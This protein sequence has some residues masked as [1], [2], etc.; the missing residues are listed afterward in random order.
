MTL[1]SIAPSL[2]AILPIAVLAIWACALL[3]V[4]LLIPRERKGITAILAALGLLVS[5]VTVLLQSGTV[6]E[7]FNGMVM[8][9]QFAIF[10]QVLFLVTGL[11]AI[12]LSFNYLRRMNLERSEYYTLLLFSV[13]GMM[14]MA[15]ANDLIIV[16]LA[17]ELLSIPLYVMAG[18]AVP[19][20]DS[21][22][23][24]LKYFLLG[25]F[26]TGIVVYGTA[27]I[28]GATGTTSLSGI[29][30]SVTSQS[31]TPGLLIAGAGL[32]LVG[33]GFKVAVV[34]FHMWTPDVYQGSPSSVTA[35]MAIGAK[36]AGFAALL[37]IFTL[38]FTE[39]ASSL[40]PVLWGLSAATMILGNVV[41]IAQH[42]IKRMLAYSSIAHAGYIL[43]ALVPYGQPEVRADSVAAALFYLVAY[44]LTSFTAWAV[45]I[46]LEQTE[47]RGLELEDYAGLSR[48]QPLLAAAMA[49]AMLSFIGVPPTVGFL[50][51]FYVFSTTLEGGFTGLALIGVLTSL[52]SAY[53]YL[54]V[55][56]LMY[57]REGKAQEIQRDP[58]LVATAG[59]TAV[60]VVLLSIFAQPLFQW[61]SQAVLQLQ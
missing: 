20:L 24:S 23:A 56:V 8:V 47:G 58:W 29:V 46:A 26:S 36:A 14:L 38:A 41:A 32:L 4:D 25:A 13:T 17:L 55:I 51:K 27:L 3:L 11:V 60:L 10:L 49:I 37:R 53:Y 18:I 22:E 33:L 52:V 12:A 28:F 54:R 31:A 44:G 1:N 59:V 61:A 15:I 7:A 40:T 21:E 16:F 9:D 30:D 57:M 45:V 42:N 50:G 39:S 5:L 35:F 19:R 43:M 6:T 48:R 2:L 34:P